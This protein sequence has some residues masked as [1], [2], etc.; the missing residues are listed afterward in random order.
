MDS[1]SRFQKAFALL[2]TFY[3]RWVVPIDERCR[4][5][6]H[7]RAA[8]YIWARY[9][10]S[11]RT[12]AVLQDPKAIP[13]VSVICRGCIEYDVSLEAV[14]KEQE[15]AR[16]YLDFETHARAHYLQI[17]SKQGDVDRLLM[18]REQ[19][20]EA[21]GEEP[22]Q[23]RHTSWCAKRKGMTGL[24]RSLNRTTELRLY[25]MLSHF[26][27]GSI[28][29]MQTLEGGITDPAETLRAMT[30]GTFDAYL[31]SSRRFI[32]FIWEPIATPDSEE[33]KADFAQIVSA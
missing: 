28:G 10:M 3:D 29:A 32:W 30:D 27:H 5:D 13:D 8:Y 22:D 19:F 33:C 18:R 23:F 21:F 7:R 9:S 25:N 31:E 11:I 1:T 24:L 16:E 15:I 6:D 17:L 26:A 14:M 4:G 20:D 12:L 2:Q